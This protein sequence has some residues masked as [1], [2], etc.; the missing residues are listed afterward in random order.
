LTRIVALCREQ[1][2]TARR[3]PTCVL[4]RFRC[5]PEVVELDGS[6]DLGAVTQ[7]MHSRSYGAAILASSTYKQAGFMRRPV[8]Q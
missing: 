2:H 7:A 5:E 1:E 8:E 4:K 6:L 3:K